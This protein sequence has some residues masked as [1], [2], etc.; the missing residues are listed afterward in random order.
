M[1]LGIQHFLQLSDPLDF[2]RN[3]CT[4]QSQQSWFSAREAGERRTH[5]KQWIERVVEQHRI[6]GTLLNAQSKNADSKERESLG[7]DSED[8]EVLSGPP[9]PPGRQ[10]GCQ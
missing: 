5:L 7:D 2:V 9:L 8:L 4:A 10:P 1:L 3:S 6:K